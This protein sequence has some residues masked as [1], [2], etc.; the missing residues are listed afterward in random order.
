MAGIIL[1]SLFCFDALSRYLRRERKQGRTVI[2]GIREL[3]SIIY[4]AM[5][6][7]Q[8]PFA[9]PPLY[10]FPPFFTL[11]SNTATLATQLTQWTQ[12][13]LA[14]CRHTRTFYLD[15]DDAQR[16]S[17]WGNDALQRRLPRDARARVFQYLVKE[18][19]R[20]AWDTPGLVAPKSAD[21]L[22]SNRI[23]VFWRRPDEWGDL[24]YSWVSVWTKQ[25]QA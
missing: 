13:V 2:E 23:L 19:H 3:Q 9:F 5:Q 14:W 8:K 18:Q 1:H 24:I 17:L 20:A 4:S 11:Q 16:L 12:L 10:S 7:E 6:T 21:L 22:P 15:V 25:L